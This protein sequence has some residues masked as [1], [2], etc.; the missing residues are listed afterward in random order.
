MLLDIPDLIFNPKNCVSFENPV[1]A[2]LR[3][4]LNAK[5]IDQCGIPV[6]AF[7]ARMTEHDAALLEILAKYPEIR[8]TLITAVL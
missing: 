3:G 4:R 1:I 5:S 6:D 2:L 7:K 8:L